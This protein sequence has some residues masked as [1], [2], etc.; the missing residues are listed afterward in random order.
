VGV[1]ADSGGGS[2]H[3]SLVPGSAEAA[4]TL[5]SHLAG[6]NDYLAERHPAVGTVTVAGHEGSGSFTNPQS[7]SGT[8]SGAQSEGQSSPQQSSAGNPGSS[9]SNPGHTA[10]STVQPRL[11]S[12]A[13]RDANPA[14]LS[15]PALPGTNLATESLGGSSGSYISVM[16]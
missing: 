10:G 16:A 1:R 3:A 4:Q 12:L 15:H 7:R 14:L 8:E 6:L 11:M 5:G 2:V 13:S 9:D